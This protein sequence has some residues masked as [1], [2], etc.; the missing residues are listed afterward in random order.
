MMDLAIGMFVVPCV[1]I[2]FDVVTGVVKAAK[3]KDLSSTRM[4]EG[5]FHK[6]GEML[7][8]LFAALCH[9][10]L[11]MAPYCNLGIPSEILCFV[12]GY[13]I[14]QE[15]FSILENIYEINPDMPLS[16]MMKLFNIS[17]ND[18]KDK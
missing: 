13:V 18:E 9:A 14:I 4:R 16:D 6:F 12:S 5:A 15:C 8:L 17:K 2:I 11:T 3:A 1:F 7:F 10:T